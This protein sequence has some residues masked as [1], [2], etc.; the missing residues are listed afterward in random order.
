MNRLK[1]QGVLLT[2]LAGSVAMIGCGEDDDPMPSPGLDAGSDAGTDGAAPMPAPGPM[3]GGLLDATI[4][5]GSGDSATPVVNP[6]VCPPQAQR[7]QEI[8]KGEITANTTWTCAKN[9]VLSGYVAVKG[10]A[11]LKIT[12][13]T[14]IQGDPTAA[15][16][17]TR[18]GMI[19]AVGTPA[20]PIVFTGFAAPGTRVAGSWQG[21]VLLG[22]ATINIGT[23]ET[24]FEAVPM[25]N[26]NGLYG[27]TD[28]THN[29]G[30]LKYV[31]L[32]FAGYE[33]QPTKELNTLTVCGC[34]SKT[35]IDY[36]QMHKGKD[37]GIEF[38][39]G[40]AS[41]KHLVITGA[42]DDSIDWDLGWRGRIQFAAIQ[43]HP[44]LAGA[45]GNG[46]E[47]ANREGANLATPIAAP[48]IYNVTMIGQKAA[49]MG[50]LRAMT[51]KDGTLGEIKNVLAMN[52]PTL[53]IDVVTKESADGLRANPPTLSVTNSIFF[54]NG[55]AAGMFPIMDELDDGLDEGAFFATPALMNKIG[56]TF[57]PKLPNATNITTPGWVPAADSAAATGGATPP[58]DGFFDPTAT[59]IGA[60][61]PAG[62]DWT[63]GWTAYPAN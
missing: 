63:A 35:T 16:F 10:G 42:D 5:G 13:G 47:G 40:T 51:L 59:Y 17:I 56:P 29:C 26:P 54:D 48:R 60:F 14:V 38:F 49:P 2:A 22:K 1:L 19:D 41:A 9:Y 20:S 28:D 45:Q 33:F 24:Q 62:D 25:G 23:Q 8:V 46:F 57:D 12:E 21:L 4:Q 44:T 31:R 6:V 52:F 7:P 43:Q 36:V 15:L 34:G 53:A 55:G 39:G 3:D 30:T 61:K 37:D 58:S 11:T 27:G 18:E 32:E 50:Q